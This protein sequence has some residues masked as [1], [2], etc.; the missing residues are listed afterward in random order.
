[1]SRIKEDYEK[2]YNGEPIKGIDITNFLIMRN[3]VE[4]SVKKRKMFVILCFS[5]II[6]ALFFT[7]IVFKFKWAGLIKIGTK[8]VGACLVLAIFGGVLIHMAL[9]WLLHYRAFEKIRRV[10]LG[11]KNEKIYLKDRLKNIRFKDIIWLFCFDYK[12]AKYYKNKLSKIYKDNKN[13]TCPKFY[14]SEKGMCIQCHD[15][16]KFMIK[17]FVKFSNWMNLSLSVFLIMLIFAMFIFPL[18]GHFFVM[19][20]SLLFYRLFSRSLEIAIAFYK[21]VVRVDRLIFRYNKNIN[22]NQKPLECY[23]YKSIYLHG[24][25]NSYLRKP[26]RISLAVH[27]F[28]EIL[29]MFSMVYLLTFLLLFKVGH[30]PDNIANYVSGEYMYEFFLYALSISFFNISYINFTCVFWNVFHFW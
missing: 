17:F 3:E 22:A 15:T 12:M 8:E 2:V 27:S 6:L 16:I 14:I 29:V 18:N 19:I 1:M 21:D 4:G 13:C 24:W 23:K 9:S 26:M 30:V 25:R 5:A 28:L 7:E 20:Y 10:Y 11:E